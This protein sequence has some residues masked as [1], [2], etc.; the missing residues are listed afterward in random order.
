MSGEMMK[1]DNIDNSASD[2]EDLENLC[3]FSLNHM[4]SS[5]QCTWLRDILQGLKTTLVKCLINLLLFPTV[6]HSTVYFLFHF[7][8]D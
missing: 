4:A 5:K 8:L 1:G 6:R 3:S 2:K 7:V